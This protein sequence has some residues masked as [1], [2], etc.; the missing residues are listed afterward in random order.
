[1]WSHIG[2]T[3]C[4]ATCGG[5]LRTVGR[6]LKRYSISTNHFRRLNIGSH[7]DPI[8]TKVCPWGFFLFSIRIQ[9]LLNP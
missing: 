9:R 2:A 5:D 7:V 1:M 3:L 6:I 4:G 8:Q